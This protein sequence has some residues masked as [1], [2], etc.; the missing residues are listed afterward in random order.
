MDIECVTDL[1]SE[2]DWWS[3]GETENQDKNENVNSIVETI[4]DLV[5]LEIDEIENELRDS[6]WR[7]FEE[8][9]EQVDALLSSFVSTHIIGK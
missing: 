5:D 8:S 4:D 1:F 3:D 2:F 9:E 7:V 6:T